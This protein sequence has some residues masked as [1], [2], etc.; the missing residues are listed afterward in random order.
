VVA[1]KARGVAVRLILDAG[2][3]GNQYSKHGQLCAAGIPVKT[4]NW[5]GKSHSKWAVADA[6]LPSA[7][8]VVYGSMNWTASGDG[9]NDENS[10]Y[11][12]HAALAAAFSGEFQRQWNDLA[13]VP[14]CTTVSAE[15]ADSSVCTP[16][17]DCHTCAS[18]SCCDGLDNDYDGRTDLQEE[19][20]AC[21]DGLDNDGDGYADAADFDC[22]NLPDP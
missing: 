19:A 4:E 20:C 7:A 17:N 14:S 6:A 9:Q 3:A 16:G 10:L 5:G 8:A 2:G 21:A 22:Q 13:A 15:G 1:A 12:K 11:V 18:G